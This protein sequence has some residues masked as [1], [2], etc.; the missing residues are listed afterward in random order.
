MQLNTVID[1]ELMQ[2]AVQI[3]GLQTVKTVI[4]EALKLLVPRKIV[5]TEKV[6]EEPDFIEEL[7]ASPLTPTDGDGTPLSRE[8]L[9]ANR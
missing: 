7:L 4:E 6:P 8:E 9:Y 3:N 5:A 2:K 1:S